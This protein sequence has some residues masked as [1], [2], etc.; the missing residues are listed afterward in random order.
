MYK[1]QILNKVSSLSCYPRWPADTFVWPSQYFYSLYHTGISH[2]DDY[3]SI[4]NI[5]LFHVSVRRYSLPIFNGYKS[6]KTVRLILACRV[7]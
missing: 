5:F 1:L 6:Q 4:S 7:L 3:A 2:Y